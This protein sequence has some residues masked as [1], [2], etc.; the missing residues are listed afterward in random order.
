MFGGTKPTFG[1]TSSGFG[2][3]NSTATSSPFGQSAFGKP[4]T[5]AFG[6]A[7]AFGTQTPSLFGTAGTSTFGAANTS[8]AFGST[9]N[10][11][12]A[13]GGKFIIIVVQN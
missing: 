11:A 6:A 13:F 7:P 1:S 12:P 10:A 3:N 9:T 5:S 8:T 4:A 2:F